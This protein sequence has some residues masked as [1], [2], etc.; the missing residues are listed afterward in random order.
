MVPSRLPKRNDSYNQQRKSWDISS[1]SQKF[2]SLSIA[3]SPD[4]IIVTPCYTPSALAA[5]L[6][7]MCEAPLILNVK[8]DIA[9]SIILKHEVEY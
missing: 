9:E 1:C 6:S 7:L 2:K 3:S 8:A 5:G 4:S